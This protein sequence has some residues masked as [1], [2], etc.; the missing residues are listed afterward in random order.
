MLLSLMDDP[1]KLPIAGT[2]VWSR[3]PVRRMAG[4]KELGCI[5]T[6]MRAARKPGARSRACS[7]ASCS[8]R[9]PRIPSDRL[10]AGRFALPSR[11]P[12]TWSGVY[13]EVLQ[14]MRET[15]LP[16]LSASGQSRGFSQGT[17]TGRGI[18]PNLYATV[19][20]HPEY[21]DVEDPDLER[22]LALAEHP[23]VIAIGE[24]GA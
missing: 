7:V 22:L 18:Q 1:A 5:S 23:R 11:F 6:T 9:V 15:R 17:G 8:R 20:V 24:T 16:W 19:G 13:L 3:R 2:V 4:R 21:T 14:R 10:H 12:L